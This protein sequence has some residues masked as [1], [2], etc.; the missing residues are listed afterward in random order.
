M[1]D[2]QVETPV[3]EDAKNAAMEVA[4]VARGVPIDEPVPVD[5]FAFDETLRV[6]LPDNVSWVEHKVLN[7]GQRRKYLNATNRNVRFKKTSGDAEMNLAPG[8]EK[9]ELLKV[10]I[11]NWNLTKGGISQPFRLDT[12]ENFLNVANPKVVDLIHKEIVKNN[13]WLM[14]EMSVEDIDREIAALQETRAV[15]VLEEEGKNDLNAR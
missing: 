8:T 5:Y 1:T 13:S 2:T 11:T 12:L 10:A 3:D 9:A 4:M 7:E 14:A 6:M 15:K